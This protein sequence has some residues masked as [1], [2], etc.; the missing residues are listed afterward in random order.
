MSRPETIDDLDECTLRGSEAAR[1]AVAEFASEPDMV[2]AWGQLL[3]AARAAGYRISDDGVIYRPPTNGELERGLSYQQK[4]WDANEEAYEAALDGAP[5]PKYSYTLR[6]WCR[7]E[8]HDYPYS[9][10]EETQR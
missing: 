3:Q 8:G 2:I 10:T 7:R 9:N 4:V 1:A 6:E 5:E